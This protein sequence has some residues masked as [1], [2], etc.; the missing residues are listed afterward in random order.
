MNRISELFIGCNSEYKDAK[1]VIFGAPYD[2]TTSYRPGTRYASRA[3]RTES[4]YGMESYSPY[5]DKDLADL[6]VNDSGDIELAFGNSLKAVN[7]IE[8]CATDI[9]NHNKIPVMIGGEHLVSLGTVK[10]IVKKY[11]NVN[12]IHFDAHLDLREEIL[13]ETLSHGTVMRRIWD[14]I[15]DNRIFQFGIRSGTKE[16][17]N[18]ASKH[19]VTNRYNLNGLDDVIKKLTGKP[20]YVSL[21][22]DVLDPSIMPGTGTPE[23]G[24]VMFKELLDAIIKIGKLNIVGYDINELSPVLDNS[25]SSTVVACKLLREILISI[26]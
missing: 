11:P 26:A 8:K 16:E 1:I 3:M 21:D 22:L 14:I 25:G 6:K 17:F 19:V 5:Q 2:S 13:G 12:I 24:G 7:D 15:G 20:V 10:A 4:I 9:L 23:A 18:F